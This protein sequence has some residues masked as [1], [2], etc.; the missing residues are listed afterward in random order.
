MSGHAGSRSIT[1]VLEHDPEGTEHDPPDRAKADVGLPPMPMVY[2][3]TAQLRGLT[4]EPLESR[5]DIS[6]RKWVWTLC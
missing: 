1:L 6:A 2:Y 4:V 3:V 5:V